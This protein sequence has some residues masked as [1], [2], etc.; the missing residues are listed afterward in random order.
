MRDRRREE[1]AADPRGGGQSGE[2]E[3]AARWGGESGAGAGAGGEADHAG[4]VGQ[5][6]AGEGRADVSGSV[7]VR[8]CKGVGMVG[9]KVYRWVWEGIPE[10]NG[11]I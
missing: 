8:M 9:G 3:Q 2:G 5:L 10:E 11:H 1:G 7:K 6:W 4:A